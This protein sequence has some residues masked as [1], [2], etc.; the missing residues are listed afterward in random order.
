M[1]RNSSSPYATAHLTV[2]LRTRYH[3][4][5][6]IDYVLS[7][8]RFPVNDC[9]GMWTEGVG[10]T[11]RRQGDALADQDRG[12][13]GDEADRGDRQRPIAGG[14]RPEAERAGE[15]DAARGR[16]P[17]DG[18]GSLNDPPSNM[19]APVTARHASQTQLTSAS[20]IAAHAC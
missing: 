4:Y 3:P 20:S 12:R 15:P 18:A 10:P 13:T 1:A 5:H 17:A 2:P 14:G 6:S 9:A 16:N 11:K 19:R 8:D 7:I